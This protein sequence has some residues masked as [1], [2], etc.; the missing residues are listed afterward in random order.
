MREGGDDIRYLNTL[1]Q[2]IED[3][4]ASQEKATA[5]QLLKDLKALINERTPH[6]LGIMKLIPASDMPEWRQ[7]IVEAVMALEK[8]D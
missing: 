7:K 8:T 1:E 4:P 5:E 6:A 2:A 3:A